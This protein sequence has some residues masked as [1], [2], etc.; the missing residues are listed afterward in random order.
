M[1]LGPSRDD[2]LP[3]MRDI[4]VILPEVIRPAEL[5]VCGIYIVFRDRS[6]LVLKAI[7]ALIVGGIGHTTNPPL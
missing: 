7:D 5:F 4:P 2:S 6:C 3:L 1:C